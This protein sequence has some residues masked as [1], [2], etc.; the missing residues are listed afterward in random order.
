MMLRISSLFIE[1]IVLG[2]YCNKADVPGVN[3]ENKKLEGRKSFSTQRNSH[4]EH[5][6]L[7]ICISIY[8]M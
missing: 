7:C 1:G 8:H 3:D 6:N 4:I 2:D 5:I